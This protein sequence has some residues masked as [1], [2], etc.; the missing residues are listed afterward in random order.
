MSQPPISF[1]P[2]QQGPPQYTSNFNAF[3]PGSNFNPAMP[4]G[5]QYTQPQVSTFAMPV[6]GMNAFGQQQPDQG[7][8]TFFN[9]STAGMMPQAMNY[10]HI[11]HLKNVMPC[12]EREFKGTNYQVVF[13]NN[14]ENP[15]S[16]NFDL[17]IDV[18]TCINVGDHQ[19]ALKLQVPKEF[20]NQAPVLFSKSG[21][22]HSIINK[23]SQEIDY[24]SYYPWEKKTS[25]AVDL[26]KA[27][28]KYF[29]SNSPFDNLEG[30][31]FDS[32]LNNIEDRAVTKLKDLDVKSFYNNL[33]AEDK[34]VVGNSDQF[35]TI[36]LLKKTPEYKAVEENKK[37]LASCIATLAQTVA[38]EVMKAESTFKDMKKAQALT[39]DS[40]SE[41]NNLYTSVAVEQQR[42]D[43]NNVVHSI[44]QYSKKIEENCLPEKLNEQLKEVCDKNTL[45]KT[46]TEFIKKRTEFNKMAIIK[47]KLTG[48]QLHA[49][50]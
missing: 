25:K 5:A 20:P 38:K 12:L 24:K 28:E 43:K 27:T 33:S 26:I 19:M 34:K 14:A 13:I 9:R 45:D 49:A 41:L 40:T 44:E 29:R 48:A 16:K 37:I 2:G 36:D 31:K 42:F 10:Q 23:L 46:I 32:I 18:E 17:S 4:Y 21:V 22:A 7:R 8:Q 35:K 47:G 11:N 50:N 6:P 1:R 30:K 3:V 15:G 39:E